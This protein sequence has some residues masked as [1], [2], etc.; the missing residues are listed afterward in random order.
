MVMWACVLLTLSAGCKT[1]EAQSRALRQA[2]DNSDP[3]TAAKEAGRF[4]KRPKHN[5]FV[6]WRL[7]Q[8][9]AL[10]AAGQ[11][12]ESNHAFDLAEDKV[13]WHEGQAK[14][15][16]GR[17]AAA[18]LSNQAALPYD[19]RDYDKIML[20]AYKA[21]NY[22]QIGDDDRARVELIRAYQRQQDAVE[23][24]KRRIARAQEAAEKLKQSKK[25][26]A[27]QATELAE[28][29]KADSQFAQKVEAAYAFLDELKPYADYVNPF[30]VYLDAL[31]FL[32]RA[33]GGS[34]L[35]RANK[36]FERVLGFTGENKFIVQDLETMKAVFRGQSIPPTTYV[37]FETGCAPVRE[38]I[39]IDIPAF[40][41]GRGNVPYVGAAFPTLKPQEGHLSGLNVSANGTN[42]MTTLLSSMDGVI[43]H[44]FKNELPTII[45]KTLISTIMKAAVSYGINKSASDQNAW[46]GLFSK[47][48]TAVYQA[49]VN[50]A[51]TR[52]WTT[53]PKEFQFCR[54]PTPSDG[55]IEL[56]APGGVPNAEVFVR[57]GAVNLVY[58]KS[59][60]ASGPLLVQQFTLKDAPSRVARRRVKG[61]AE[62]AP[63]GASRLQAIAGLEHREANERPFDSLPNPTE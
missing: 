2:W 49:A 39:R 59:I 33:T 43:G 31:Y 40:F 22:L 36:S 57:P 20:N 12:E 15:S 56:S 21:L 29:V 13:N 9:A 10:R 38:Q 61:P 62:F 51:D 44:S 11:Y 52:T 14:V 4:A 1:Y 24:N 23:E 6:I 17:E 35:E 53:L 30:V 25:K 8:G 42:E 28:K 63:A 47:I 45:T 54:I 41:I 19:G 27:D 46:V 18:L 16:L 58:V 60:R 3:Q 26:G 32:T 37:I 34:D 7:E 50:I 5:D 48:A 55:K